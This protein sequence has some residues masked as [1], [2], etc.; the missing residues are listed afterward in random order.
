MPAVIRRTRIS[1][2]PRL[3]GLYRSL[4][5]ETREKFH[6]ELFYA[7]KKIRLWGHN[8]CFFLSHIAFTRK[9]LKTVLPRGVYLVLV[10][11][12]TEKKELIGFCSL[13]FDKDSKR[14]NKASLSIVVREEFQGKGYGMALLE[15]IAHLAMKEGLSSINLIVNKTNS[16]A[17]NLYSKF[18]F[19]IIGELNMVP[20]YMGVRL[21]APDERLPHFRMRLD[22]AKGG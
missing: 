3:H 1:D 20:F 8:I 10:M 22:L 5:E 12:E 4:A 9:L 14:G 15:Q 2:I 11:E 16:S 7:R 18:G 19:E 13:K 21:H 17:V 6:P